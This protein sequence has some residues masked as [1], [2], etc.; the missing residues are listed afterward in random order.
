MMSARLLVAAVALAGFGVFAATGFSGTGE[1][2]P[3]ADKGPPVV[4]ESK[5]V[6]AVEAR[7]AGAV[8]AHRR[9]RFR[10]QYRVAVNPTFV[11]AGGISQLTAM[12]CPRGWAAIAGFFR[13]DRAV[14]ADQFFK[15]RNVRLWQFGFADLTGA[16]NGRAW[17][18]VVCARI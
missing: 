8:T 15:P 17:E 4:K 13:T 5:R 18:G 1:D 12:T 3:K 11:P 14:V 2:D 7:A 10:V 16:L 6:S 9:D